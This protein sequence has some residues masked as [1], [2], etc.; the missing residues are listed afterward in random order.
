MYNSHCNIYIG[1]VLVNLQEGVVCPEHFPSISKSTEVE[2]EFKGN[3]LFAELVID[4]S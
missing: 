2:V 3:G 1:I 4:P